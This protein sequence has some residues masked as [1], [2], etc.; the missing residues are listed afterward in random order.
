MVGEACCLSYLHLVVLLWLVS[1]PPLSA[2]R[3]TSI[4]RWYCD[5][6]GLTAEVCCLPYLCLEALPRQFWGRGCGASRGSGCAAQWR[7]PPPPPGSRYRRPR[8]LPNP[9][10]T[11]LLVKTSVTLRSIVKHLFSAVSPA[12]FLL[13]LATTQ[14]PGTYYALLYVESNGKKHLMQCSGSASGSGGSV[15]F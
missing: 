10:S 6:G 15:C 1:W 8:I 4:W 5:I 13:I 9:S 2:A 11:I 12:V 14:E 7:V 3:P